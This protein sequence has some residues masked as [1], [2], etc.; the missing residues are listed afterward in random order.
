MAKYKFSVN[1]SHVYQNLNTSTIYKLFI[2]N[3]MRRKCIKFGKRSFPK[4][5]LEGFI[6]YIFF[7]LSKLKIFYNI[8]L[9]TF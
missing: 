9:K 1:L 2:L 6:I 4:S 5:Y 3:G 7:M 8:F